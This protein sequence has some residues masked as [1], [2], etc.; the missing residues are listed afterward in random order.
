[1]IDTQIDGGEVPVQSYAI[2]HLMSAPYAI[3]ECYCGDCGGD[4]VPVHP[5]E[6]MIH[7]VDD[8]QFDTPFDNQI[9]LMSLMGNWREKAEDVYSD[10]LLIS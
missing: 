10:D 1:M 4:L 5:F 2:G 9:G 6:N 3:S 7:P 8:A